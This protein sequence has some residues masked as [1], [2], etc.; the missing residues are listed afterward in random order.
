MQ[1]LADLVPSLVKG[2][3]IVP[4][5]TDDETGIKN[6]NFVVVAVVA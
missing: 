3:K 6:V 4:L 5:V 2:R 1:N